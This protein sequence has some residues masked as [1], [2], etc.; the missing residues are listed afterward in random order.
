MLAV[1]L[2]TA[3]FATALIDR[4]LLALVLAPAYLAPILIFENI[5]RYHSTFSAVVLA[6]LL[7]A[8]APDFIRGAWR[9]PA[10]WRAALVCWM[11]VVCVTTPIVVARTVDFHLEL[12]SR[13]RSP[14]EALG[15]FPL[16]T[17]AWVVHSSLLLVVGALW[18]DWLRGQDRAYVE[19]WIVAPLSVGAGALVLVLLWQMFVDI[20]FLN[21]TVYAHLRRAGGTVMDA[22]AAGAIA[23]WWVGAAL[24][25]AVA[26]S[27]ARR[28][29]WLSIAAV[30]WI[31]VWATGSRTAFGL[32]GLAT[33]IGS[34]ALFGAQR[35][36]SSRTVVRVAGAV[37]IGGL[38]LLLL[39][40]L[41]MVAA[42]PM[43]RLRAMLPSRDLAGMQAVASE[44]WNRNGYGTVATNVI[45]A[46]PAFGIG[47]GTFH[48]IATEYAPK[49]PPDNAQNWFRH[50]IAETG[51]VGSLGWIVL[52][53]L[54]A[55]WLIRRPSTES[56]R[57]ARPL[58]G[59]LVGFV[60]IS[61]LGVPGQDLLV[62]LTLWTFAAWYF[63]VSGWPDD[64]SAKVEGTRPAAPGRVAW[65]L[66]LVVIA[67]SAVGTYVAAT[68]RLRTPARI[69][70]MGGE[71]MYG[72]SWPEADPQGGEFRWARTN[73]TAIV[74]TSSRT[75]ELTLRTN[76][77]DLNDKPLHVR[78]W[79]DGRRVVD[80]TLTSANN[81]VT[82]IVTIPA[83]EQRALIDIWADRA[84]TAPPPDARELAVM[85]RWRFVAPSA[86]TAP[87]R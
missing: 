16:I 32:A 80:T 28:W 83:G 79:V 29:L 63:H 41:P 34:T 71:Y 31:A 49:L 27:G 57:R 2:F 61:L 26:A 37:M 73:A 55:W 35:A 69:Q 58:L 38:G 43:A 51:V 33:V 36:T 3:G 67:V 53:A 56:T 65:T 77:P 25:V 76:R 9:I 64:A 47:I 15:G 54:M 20:T 50:Q 44:L 45:N 11:G 1:T 59:A 30:L 39:A 4:R 52:F 23:A 12:L 60:A 62:A 14:F 17:A 13:G 24:F 8:I 18:F 5:G 84:I 40:Q 7:G 74:V 78:A 22:N 85:V 21:P 42:G 82:H 72:F 46:Y 68:G 81:S 66:A 10:Q 86:F 48:D 70:R 87:Q 6:P 19:R 75:L